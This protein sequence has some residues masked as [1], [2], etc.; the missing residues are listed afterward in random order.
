MLAD[1]R[2]ASDGVDV[3]LIVLLGHGRLTAGAPSSI[4]EVFRL[5]SNGRP[6]FASEVPIL[7]LASFGLFLFT[8]CVDHGPAVLRLAPLL[9]PFGETI[10]AFAIWQMV[11]AMAA[12]S[13]S[14]DRLM[15]EK[16]SDGLAS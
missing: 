7:S 16:T 12:A 13:L 6:G 15:A 11:D 10:T 1:P 3:G 14:E 8:T 4:G 2:W 5:R 9:A